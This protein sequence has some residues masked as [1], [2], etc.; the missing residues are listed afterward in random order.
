MKLSFKHYLGDRSR[1]KEEAVPSVFSFKKTPQV[2]E[3]SKRL[4]RRQL[5]DEMII[6][7]APV[8]V[9]DVQCEV[10]IYSDVV[11]DDQFVAESTT[12]I[13]NDTGV[14]CDLLKHS[15][16]S[17]YNCKLDPDAVAFY[18]G[19]PKYD[20]FMYKILT[21]PL[22]PAYVHLSSRIDFV[23]FSLLN[24]R[25]CIKVH[26]CKSANKVSINLFL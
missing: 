4:K 17:I 7:T 14:G 21:K 1:L 11:E 5:G 24:F 6:D 15:R 26:A 25:N 19:F 16:Y 20:H 18:T 3:R 2:S 8:V 10:E 13:T 9:N 22:P 12:C 23:C